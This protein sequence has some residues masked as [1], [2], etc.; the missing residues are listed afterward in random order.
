MDLFDYV[1]SKMLL[2][3][4]RVREE[5]LGWE[6]IQVGMYILGYA[7]VYVWLCMLILDFSMMLLPCS[8]KCLREVCARVSEAYV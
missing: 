2:I 8:M 5:R 4:T 7:L 6:C 3:L 1:W